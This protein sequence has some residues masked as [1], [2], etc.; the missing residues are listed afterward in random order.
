MADQIQSPMHAMYRAGKQDI[1]A[2]AELLSSIGFRLHDALEQ[3]DVQSALAGDPAL[4]TSMLKVGGDVFDV[5]RSA[6][7]S[8]NNCAEAVIAT[9]DDFRATDE[10]AA[11]DYD[12]LNAGLKNTGGTSYGAPPALPDLAEPGATQPDDSGPRPGLSDFEPRDPV[13]VPSTPDPVD[14]GTDQEGRDQ[15]EQ[16]DKDDNPVVPPEV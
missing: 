9:A 5:M 8:L 15:T 4:M 11:A 3:L 13:E 7:I 10:Q 2:E 6:V 1:P 14:P 16:D 12:H